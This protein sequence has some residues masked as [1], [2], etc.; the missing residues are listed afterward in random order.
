[1]K[2]ANVWSERWQNGDESW[3]DLRINSSPAALEAYRAGVAADY[4]L[5]RDDLIRPAAG[6]P[7]APPA[8]G[9][10]LGA[11]PGWGEFE[12]AVTTQGLT[13]FEN[14]ARRSVAYSPFSA[15]WGRDTATRAPLDAIDAYGAIPELRLM[16]WGAPYEPGAQ[17]V[18]ALQRIIDGEFDDYLERWADEAAAFGKPMFAVFAVEMNGDWFPWSGTFNGG[19]TTDGYGD[20]AKADGPERYVDA[21][22]H[23]VDLFRARGVTNVTWVWQ[24]NN[25]S[26]PAEEWN[27]ATAYYPGDDY[28]D[29]VG[30]SAYGALT[31]GDDWR[32]FDDA[33]AAAY[34]EIT[35]A[36]PGK[37]LM[38]AEWGC[39]ER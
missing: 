23:I 30:I 7:I 20:P 14:L 29:W 25:E 11:Y 2:L 9:C 38:L 16:P 39:L 27:A 33:F 32:T 1:M 12:D 15:Y 22:R 36:Y 35:A 8:E 19:G 6:E 26:F 21:Y 4:Y 28:V 5:D 13:D 17:P 37:P 10:Y 34:A 31:P 24:V 18:Y 3:S